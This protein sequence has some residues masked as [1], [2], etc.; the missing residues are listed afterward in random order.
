MAVIVWRLVYRDGSGM[1]VVRDCTKI[2]RG[3]QKR[4]RVMYF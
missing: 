4:G 3:V 1:T 2:I